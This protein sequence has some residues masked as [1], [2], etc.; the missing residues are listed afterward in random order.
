MITTNYA[1]VMDV[2]WSLRSFA[3]DPA[4][5]YH[6]AWGQTGLTSSS[7]RLTGF[8]TL[9]HYAPQLRF[10]GAEGT[11]PLT[12]ASAGHISIRLCAAGEM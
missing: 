2:K 7:A 8:G 5:V 6:E 12:T 10:F 9:T 11:F 1:A 3:W 4:T